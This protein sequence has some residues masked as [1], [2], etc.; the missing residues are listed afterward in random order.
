MY[1][2]PVNAVTRSAARGVQGQ[3]VKREGR[4][5]LGTPTKYFQY[6]QRELALLSS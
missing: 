3:E 5:I 4:D 1:P 6:N 2:R